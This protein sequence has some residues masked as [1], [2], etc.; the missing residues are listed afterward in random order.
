MDDL[1]SYYIVHVGG[2]T[3][4]ASGAP[5]PVEVNFFNIMQFLGNLDKLGI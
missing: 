4:A 5:L 3:G 2:F 1:H